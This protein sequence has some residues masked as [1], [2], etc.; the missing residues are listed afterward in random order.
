MAADLVFAF[1]AGRCMVEV[2]SPAGMDCVCFKAPAV[3][4]FG[5]TG[6]RIEM[7]ANDAKLLAR[8]AKAMGLGIEVVA[9]P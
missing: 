2:L 5:A 9:L 4:A 3:D 7:G 8:E 1:S 6:N